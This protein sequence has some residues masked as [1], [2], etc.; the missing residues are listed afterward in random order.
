[1]A[2]IPHKSKDAT[3]EALSAIQEA[4]SL[5]Q[6]EPRA[7]TPPTSAT[8][9]LF[10]DEQQRAEWSAE[11]NAP[12]RAA[13][14]DR[15]SIGQLLQTLH[16]R[17]ARLPYMVAT[18]AA[19]VWAGGG[20]IA[21]WLF[22]PEL[23]AII[24]TPRTGFVALVGFAAVL[25]VPVIF[26]FVLAH[27][28]RR[29]QD[30]RL[31]AESMAQV[32]MRLAQPEA[33]AR[34]SIVTVG[35]AIRREVAAMGDGV[36]RALAR[37][38]ELEALVHNEVSALERAYN[39]NEVRIRDLVS[40][41]SNQRET[42]VNQAEQ[43]RN[44]IGS[45]HLDLSHDITSVGDLVAEKVNEVAQRVTRSLTEKGEHIT[46]ALG[47]AGDSMI[48]A[49]TDR[50]ANLLDRLETTSER[51]SSAISSA[52]ERLT[53]SLNFKTE[54]VHDEFAEL[55]ARLQQMMTARLDTVAQGFAQKAAGTVE[56]MAGRTQVFTETL[57]DTGARM[58]E[59][60]AARAEEVNSTLR[61]TGDSLVL[62]LSLR[63]GD[64]VSKLEQTGQRITD[65]MITRSNAVAETF[66]DNAEALAQALNSRG[67][68]VKDML[69]ARLQA[70]EDMFNHG[71]TELT[72]KISRDS[73]TLG[74]LITSHLA[75][76]DHTVKTYGGELVQ[77]LGQRTQ[78]VT[79][80]MHNYLDTFDQRVTA[81]S[82]TVGGALDQ[83]LTQFEQ[84]LDQRV[85]ALSRN[86]TVGGKAV[87]DMLDQRIS[88]A[89]G[90][91]TARGSEVAEAID[92]KAAALDR[93]LGARAQEVADNL[94]SRIGRFE[95]LLVGRAETVTNQIET[96]TRA[97]ADA[98][99][100]RM[101]QLS[102]SIK[103]NSSEAERSL[104]QLAI[105]TS[106]AIRASAGEAERTLKGVSDEVATSFIGKADEIANAV[107]QRTS[108]MT[109]VLSDRSGSVLAAIIEKGQQF[110]NDVG[111]ATDQAIKSIDEKGFAFTR[112]MLDNSA[113]LARMI[114]SA[115]E[116]AS[117]TVNRT[118]NDLNDTAQKAIEQSK[119][120]ATSTVSEMMETHNMLRADTTALF[121]RLR[122]AN[123]ML[124]EVLSGAHENM[125]AL[126]NT[127]MLRVS[128]FVSA[129][130]EVTSSTGEATGRVE[131]TIANFGEI[132]SRVVTD[133]GQLADQF[134]SHGRDLAKAVD[135]I[136]H[137][138]TRT[139][140]TINERR[141]QL[142]SL[143]STLD[144]RTEDLDQ[145]LKRFAGL[146]DESLEAASARARDVARVVSESSAEGSRAISEQYE[147]VREHA[148]DERR[149]AA[150]A[151]RDVFAQASGDS[152]AIFRDAAER[153][154]EVVQGMKQM[155]AEMQQELE[156]TRSEL[157][158]GI[159]ELP[160]ETAESTAQ[161][162]R[163]I[164]DQIEALAELNRIVARHGRSLDAVEPMR[165][166]A[167]E[168]PTLAVIGGGRSDMA[169]RSTP[170]R[171]EPSSFA[172]P[173]RRQDAPTLTPAQAGVSRGWLSE[174][175][176]R[177]SRDEEEPARELPR[178]PLRDLPREPARAPEERTPA[179]H[180]R[181]ARFIVGRHRPHD[182]SR[183]GRRPVGPLQARRT[184]CLHPP[185][186]HLAGA[187]GVRRDPQEVPRRPRVQADGRPLRQ[188]VRAAARRGLA[189][190]P[191]PG[192]G[193]HV[194]DLGDRQ[195][196]HH[197]GARGRPL[198]LSRRYPC[199]KLRRGPPDGPSA[200][201]SQSSAANFEL[202]RAANCRIVRPVRRC[203]VGVVQRLSSTMRRRRQEY[204]GRGGGV[205][206]AS[207]GAND[208]QGYSGRISHAQTCYAC[209][210]CTRT[211]GGAFRR[212]GP[213]RAFGLDRL[214]AATQGYQMGHRPGRLIG[215][216]GARGARRRS[217]QG[218]AGITHHRAALSRRGRHREGLC[219]R[220]ARRLLRLRR[221]VEGARHR[222]RP[223][224]GLQVAHHGAARPI[225]LVL[226]ARHRHRHQGE[227]PRYHQ[228]VGRPHRQGRLYRPAAV[229]H[230]L[231]SRERA[232][233][234]RR[235]AHL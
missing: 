206:P 5:R 201:I 218:D 56:N 153:F 185:A 136:D 186:L 141:V 221:G 94:D 44:A 93:T 35:Q 158:R 178:E 169:P 188:R 70:F 11:E 203:G 59:T 111:S 154:A 46:L 216:Q 99:N 92:A 48:D 84:D 157:H 130:N 83:R 204:N 22:R 33:V 210:H 91:I 7:E 166:P 125:S 139:E 104:G 112:S 230:A 200:L 184:Q 69:A 79:D 233:R 165:R 147:R 51:A 82:D 170:P 174:L 121:E 71:G 160:Q 209:D 123:I 25:A 101:E 197:A 176:T 34:E 26:F 9:D 146:L 150:E 173:P 96:R 78:D 199:M 217:Q 66:R 49:L 106:D 208:I 2:N 20:L 67:E 21:A 235:Q 102:Q 223:L 97:A 159:F 15:A 95:E 135:L 193:A 207:T 47:H 86:L 30:L 127:L 231:A 132:T 24:A 113:E 16:R 161:M 72:E 155:S 75:E 191:R 128:E 215:P 226:H 126:E 110:A 116:N 211:D 168:E 74:N 103:S 195:G 183:R 63:G 60:I 62:D 81:K 64:V 171:S 27:M 194:S 119:S 87:V 225:A 187:E 109:A 50:S 61:S 65:T 100:A 12:R 117:N 89:G 144:I 229:R 28:F 182:R 8:A 115:G 167:R 3:E 118:F 80:A 6:Q 90:T 40:E 23:E 224:Q 220:R 37:A 192:G 107:G 202:P 131:S 42:L 114:N 134:D 222:Q 120:T 149:R 14:D 148:D 180:H 140:S 105:A 138:N 205:T 54:H 17:P 198:R 228:E 39:D 164:V 45:V 52:S 36:E 177:A 124:Q 227:R 4:L 175:L 189:R 232:A 77:R 143:V 19:A 31:V 151:M 53:D 108:E 85:G 179:S 10:Q 98:L 57:T 76:F 152:H 196:L 156:A 122:E 58:A 68:A 234:A 145:R 133:L 55:A 213:G 73:T 162:R 163:V 13:N 219:H 137:S 190:R 181:V 1:M 129:M 43:V 38:A 32:A 214:V 29:S 18:V 142:D 88:E 41:L 172:P 212:T